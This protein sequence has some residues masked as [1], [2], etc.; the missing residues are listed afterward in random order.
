M[1]PTVWNNAVALAPALAAGLIG[2]LLATVASWALIE[3]TFRRNPARVTF[4]M[5]QAF[6]VKM[7]FFAVYV[8]VMLR[9]LTL[10]PA[11]F[12]L[13]FTTSFLTFYG[14]QAVRLHRLFSGATRAAA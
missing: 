13:S 5:H 2:P 3:R 12:M 14:V 6:L 11:A 1:T 4:L 8:G 7:A 10:P 9:V